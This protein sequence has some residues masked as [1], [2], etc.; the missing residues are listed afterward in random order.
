MHRRPLVS[1]V[2]P[3]H[4]K[5]FFLRVEAKKGHNATAVSLVRKVLCIW[6]H[7][8]INPEIYH[9]EE[10]RKIKSLDINSLPKRAEMSFEEMVRSLIWA[11]YNVRKRNSETGG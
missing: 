6:H 7:L 10:S 9:K 2:F 3:L 5:E 1:G 11:G 4:V 8:L